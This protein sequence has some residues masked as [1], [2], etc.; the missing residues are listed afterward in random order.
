MFLLID[1]WIWILIIICSIFITY[2]VEKKESSGTLAT[3]SVIIL[4][5]VL[6]FASRHTI[7]NLWN[8]IYTHIITTIMLFL[9]Y[10]T[11]GLIWSIIKWASFFF[12][13]RGASD[14]DHLVHLKS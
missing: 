8:F 1:V 12:S 3:V 2:F 14:L 7:I 5:L 10:L 9:C 6:Y 13:D 11:V 4:G